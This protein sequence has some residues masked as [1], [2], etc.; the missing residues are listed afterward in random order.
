VS[1]VLLAALSLGLLSRSANLPADDPSSPPASSSS[2]AS[3]SAGDTATSGSGSSGS[4]SPSGSVSDPFSVILD[5]N[6]PV[7]IVVELTCV[8]GIGLLSLRTISKL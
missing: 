4:A 5:P 8:A 2:A 1:I 3:S 6:Q 7:V